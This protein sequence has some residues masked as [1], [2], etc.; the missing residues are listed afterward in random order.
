MKIGIKDVRRILD[1]NLQLYKEGKKAKNIY[2]LCR[3]DLILDSVIKDWIKDNNIPNLQNQHPRIMWDENQ[4]GILEKTNPPIYVLDN[5]FVEQYLDKPFILYYQM[6]NY[7]RDEGGDDLVFDL[8][9]KPSV[10]NS[11]FGTFDMKN[12]MF[13]VA[14]GFREG[15]G[16]RTNELPE[17]LLNQFDVYELV[18]DLKSI[19]QFEYDEHMDIVNSL[20]AKDSEL[21]EKY[22]LEASIIKQLI[23]TGFNIDDCAIYLLNNLRGSFM[24]ADELTLKDVVEELIKAMETHLHMAESHALAPSDKGIEDCKAIIEWLNGLK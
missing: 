12:R 9:V 23:D 19:L 2:F 7:G 1:E 24:M 13:T 4:Y 22:E 6:F 17:R 3:H 5:R 14:Y 8:I 15:S 10:S 11:G 20:K 16:N 21:A 18:M